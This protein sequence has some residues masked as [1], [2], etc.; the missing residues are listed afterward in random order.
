MRPDENPCYKCPDQGCG[1]HAT[2]KLYL[3]FYAW[4]REKSE[5]KLVDGAIDDYTKHAV[6][7]MK[8]GRHCTADRYRPKGR[9]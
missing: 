3:R 9:W 8:S 2:C 5:K 6:E 1:K 4:N 7:K